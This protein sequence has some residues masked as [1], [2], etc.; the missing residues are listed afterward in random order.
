MSR[1]APRGAFA[2]SPAVRDRLPM[3]LEQ[4]AVSSSVGV[5]ATVPIQATAAHTE[6]LKALHDVHVQLTG[7]TPGTL[8]SDDDDMPLDNPPAPRASLSHGPDSTCVRRLWSTEHDDL[9]VCTQK[10]DDVRRPRTSS[11]R[12]TWRRRRHTFHLLL[13]LL[14]H[15]QRQPLNR[16]NQSRTARQ[17]RPVGNPVGCETRQR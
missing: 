6:V 7:A 10:K 5:G 16:C 17:P 4:K 3:S 11:R 2:D 14:L 12:R 15:H 9:D 13:Q 8:G 1:R